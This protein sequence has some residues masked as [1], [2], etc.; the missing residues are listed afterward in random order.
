MNKSKLVILAA[1]AALALFSGAARADQALFQHVAAID[2]GTQFNS[3]SGYGDNPLSVAFDGSSAYVG[4]YNNGAA[5]ANIGVVKVG[6]IFSGTPTFAQLTATQFSAPVSRGVDSLAYE[7]NTAS[8]ILHHDS[9]TAATSF[10][11][12]R[13]AGDG[14]LVWNLNSPQGA[15][16]L[17]AV[18]IDPV[19]DNGSAGIAYMVQGGGRR[20]LLSMAS[21]ATIFDSSNG[22]VINAVPTLPGTAW[23]GVAFD[24]EG[25][26]ALSE[27]SGYA[28]GVRHFGDPAN[29]YNRFKDLS[30]VVNQTARSVKKNV[31]VNNVGQGI[32]IAEDLLGVGGDLI[33]FSGRDAAT[34]TDLAG[35][36]TTVVDTK[37]QIRNLNGTVTGLTQFELNGDE[38]GIGTP[39]TGDVKNLAFGFD[40]N[41]NQVLL[42]VDFVGRRLDVYRVPEPT[43]LALL[44][45]G[46]LALLRRRSA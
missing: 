20:R 44:A 8:L 18:A 10:I 31:D 37:V 4:G 22:G 34:L 42:V 15:R 3:T 7:P 30:G 9:G 12:R 1:A 21:G 13:N 5:A 26:I 35:G 33:A 46:G 41:G 45:I 38:N 17:G 14:S 19:G 23:R 11:S 40:G 43:G 29:L 39:W 25:N 16:P 27:D 32:V 24:R 6:D 2:L 28:Y 36:V